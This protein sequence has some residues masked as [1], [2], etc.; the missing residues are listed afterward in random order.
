MT[1]TASIVTALA[2]STLLFC[3]SKARWYFKRLTIKH[4]HKCQP[5]PFTPSKDPLLG[6][7]SVYRMLRSVKENR[8]NLSLKEQLEL[9]GYTFQSNLFGRTE[10]F[11][12]EPQNLQAIFATNFENFGVEPMRPFVFEPLIGKGIMSTDGAYW[13]HSRAFLQ[14]VFS[15]TQ[16]ADYSTLEIHVARLINLIPKDRSII[17]LQPLFAKLALDSSSEFLF[18]ESLGLLSATPTNG[19]QAF[20]DNYSYAQRGIGR[21]LQLPR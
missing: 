16:L 9:Y 20:W 19:A 3:F 5:P 1:L 13:A 10:V 4:Q 17:D 6:L 7:D 12:A 2:A 14:P 21:R 11:T 18:G 8:R 15:K